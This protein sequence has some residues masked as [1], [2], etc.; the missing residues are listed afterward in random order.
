M[1]FLFR[2]FRR[3][4]RQIPSEI[5]YSR[6]LLQTHVQSISQQQRTLI[7]VETVAVLACNF[8]IQSGLATHSPEMSLLS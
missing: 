8:D 3:K 5:A 4:S 7:Y 2:M 1:K 6:L